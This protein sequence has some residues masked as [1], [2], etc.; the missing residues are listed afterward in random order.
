MGPMHNVITLKPVTAFQIETTG[1]FVAV[2]MQLVWGTHCM[3]VM[4]W[5]GKH[6]GF[7]FGTE[8][9]EEGEEVK[10]EDGEDDGDGKMPTN[11]FGAIRAA[12]KLPVLFHNSSCTA[13][14]PFPLYTADV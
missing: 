8:A 11:P 3:E 13:A 4:F 12:T 9:K 2:V 14:F 6:D 1:I 10:E 5:M 7:G